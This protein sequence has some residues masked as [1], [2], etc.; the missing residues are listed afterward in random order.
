MMT[1]NHSN[2][3]DDADGIHETTGR[4]LHTQSVAW[5]CLRMEQHNTCTHYS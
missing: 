2:G 4:E 3:D 5:N 1:H